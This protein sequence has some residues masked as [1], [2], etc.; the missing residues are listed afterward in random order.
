MRH[1]MAAKLKM[2]GSH[3]NSDIYKVFV[4]KN[5]S[6]FR[7]R[8]RFRLRFRVVLVDCIPTALITLSQRMSAIGFYSIDE[9]V[10]PFLFSDKND[11][12]MRF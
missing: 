2:K 1:L 11:V 7:V 6:R 5:G 4:L 12:Y 9:K 10:C 8:F 3:S